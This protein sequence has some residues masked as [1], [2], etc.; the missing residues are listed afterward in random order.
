M[1][2]RVVRIYGTSSKA[3]SDAHRHRYDKNYFIL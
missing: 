1:W 3:A 2:V